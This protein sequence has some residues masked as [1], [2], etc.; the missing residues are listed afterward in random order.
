MC[1]FPLLSSD[2]TQGPP[3]WVPLNAINK[4]TYFKEVLMS[5][6]RQGTLIPDEKLREAIGAAGNDVIYLGRQ[7]SSVAEVDF[8]FVL[9]EMTEEDPYKV[10]TFL[11]YDT[12]VE[13][14]KRFQKGTPVFIGNDL[15]I[16][17]YYVPYEGAA[18]FVHYDGTGGIMETVAGDLPDSYELS[19]LFPDM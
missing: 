9:S 17:A 19:T 12:A 6:K 13:V 5:N 2:K 18:Y 1:C 4:T 10:G 16:G 3:L 8:L 15:V 14:V 7:W 11:D